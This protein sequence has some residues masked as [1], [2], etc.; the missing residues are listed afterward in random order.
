MKTTGRLK[1]FLG[2][3]PQVGATISIFKMSLPKIY[4]SK[5]AIPIR[6]LCKMS[7]PKM[8]TILKTHELMKK[9]EKKGNKY[10]RILNSKQQ[11]KTGNIFI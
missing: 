5:M 3:Q 11:Q 6:Q 8:S 10:S 9:M 2:Y 7:S 1:L 4:I